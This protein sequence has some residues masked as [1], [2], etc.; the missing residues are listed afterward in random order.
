MKTIREIDNISFRRLAYLLIMIGITFA[1]DSLFNLSVVYKLWPLITASLGMGLLVIFIRRQDKKILI[2]AIGEYLLLFSVLAL[3]CNFNSWHQ[4]KF[5]WPF[6]VL[7][8]G[9]VFITSFIFQ[10]KNRFLFFLGFFLTWLSV[11]FFFLIFLG[12]QVWWTIFIVIG[13][14]ILLSIKLL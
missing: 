11:Y 14:S 13:L 7:F 4:L 12:H 5:L 3:Y 10:R 8:L 1:L 9:I 2:Q 6:F